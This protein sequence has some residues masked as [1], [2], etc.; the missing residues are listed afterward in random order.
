IGTAKPTAA[1]QAAAPHHLL[2]LIEPNKAFTVD[3][4]L[5]AARTC[6][7]DIRLRKRFPII[8]G[9]TNLYV[10]SL[11]GGFMQGPDPDPDVRAELNAMDA[12]QLRSELERVDPDA[13]ERIHQNDRRRTIRALE[14]HRL[15]GESISSLQGQW[16]AA[17]PPEDVVLIGLE[18]SA[19]AVNRR[20]NSR[21]R[22]MMDAGF[23][24]EVT[25]LHAA[26]RLGPQSRE[27][28]GYK[29]LLEHLDGQLNLEEAIEQIKIRTRRFAKQQRTWLR[30]FRQLWGG[31]WIEAEGEEAQDIANKALTYISSQAP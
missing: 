18:W 11:L 3:D 9:G 4:W 14:V 8:V 12:T 31:C 26:G 15:T 13:A 21:V 20:I 30:K 24:E 1:E 16:D 28:L 27:A 5:T 17:R 10:Q 7:D 19:E 29:Q 22:S 2:D 25:H 6:I 23:L